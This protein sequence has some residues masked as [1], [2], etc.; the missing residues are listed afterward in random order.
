M[1]VHYFDN[2]VYMLKHWINIQSPKERSNDTSPRPTSTITE[3]KTIEKNLNQNHVASVQA[4]AWW[5]GQSMLVIQVSCFN[6]HG[7]ESQV[8]GPE[9]KQSLTTT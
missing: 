9:L 6:M 8:V 7:K 2:S 4:R 5:I 3:R 1:G